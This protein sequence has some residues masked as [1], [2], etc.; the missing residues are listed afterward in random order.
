MMKTNRKF[1]YLF[2]AAFYALFNLIAFL[3]P[4]NKTEIFWIS[5]CATTIAFISQIIIWKLGFKNGAKIE[6]K[7]LG[8]PI[9]YIGILYLIVTLIAFVVFMIFSGLRPWIAII[10]FAIV[11]TIFF[12][13]LVGAMAVRREIKSIDKRISIKTRYIKSVQM[14]IELLAQQEE[15]K[16][17][18]IALTKLAEKIRYSDPISDDSINELEKTISLMINELKIADADEKIKIIESISF[19]IDTRNKEVRLLK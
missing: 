19:L 16:D 7:F 8:I 12:S 5:Y 11:T 6:S 13:C 14:E 1:A 10:T 3:I 17:N 2:L 9:I 18:K 4:A 15:N